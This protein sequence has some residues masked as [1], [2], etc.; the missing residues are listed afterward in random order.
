MALNI[1]NKN[2]DRLARKIANETGETLPE[3]IHKALAERWERLKTRQNGP[4]LASQI[5]ELLRRVDDLPV[6]DSRPE[7]EVL[8]YDEYGAPRTRTETVEGRRCRKV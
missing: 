4:A 2:I 8:S 7:G 3:V 1:K 6:L 5:E